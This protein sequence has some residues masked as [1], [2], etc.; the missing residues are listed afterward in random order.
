MKQVV[1]WDNFYQDPKALRTLILDS[2]FEEGKDKN[3]PGKNSILKYYPDDFNNFFS[4]LAGEPLKPAEG[5]HCGGFRIQNSGETGKQFIHVDL[6]NLKTTWAGICYL[7]LP[8]HYT[9]EDGSF[10]DSGSK[11]WKHKETGLEQL[12]YDE[13]FLASIGL[14]GPQDLF[15]FMNTEGTDESKWINT[16]SVPIKFNRLILF[17]SNLWHSQGELFGD[18]MENGRLIQTF[19]FEPDIKPVEDGWKKTNEL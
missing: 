3:Y 19:F 17:K 7:S 15:K 11:F 8:E 4:F 13:K 5:S 2:E 6:P 18:S 14:N 12:P 10:L 1:I 16:M 9:K